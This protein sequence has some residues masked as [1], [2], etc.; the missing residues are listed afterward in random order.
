MSK[1]AQV[2]WH[3]LSEEELL[4]K[5]KSDRYRG[6][7]SKVA[8]KRR[9]KLGENA[10]FL[11]TRSTPMDAMKAVLRDVPLLLLFLICLIAL[12]FSLWRTVI[13]VLAVLL[14]SSAMTVIAYA[15]ARHIRESM[16]SYS[17]PRV[18]LIRGGKR[19]YGRAA[20]LVP[21]DLICLQA[22]DI[23]PADARILQCSADAFVR[24]L[25]SVQ[26]GEM[27][28][29]APTT[30][31]A[32]RVY[33]A[34]ADENDVLLR[35]NMLFAGSRIERGQLTA[36]V[37]TT[38]VD[39]YH[40]ALFGGNALAAE[41]GE[42]PYL[43]R[44]RRYA[45]R[46]SILMCAMLLPA[47]LIG[48]LFGKDASLFEIFLIVLS[49]AVASMSEQ[50]MVMGRIVA[51]CG[52]VRAALPSHRGS[53]AIFKRYDT[54][55]K[56]AGL[57][58]VIMTDMSAL[59]DGMPHPYAIFTDGAMY[60]ASCAAHPSVLRFYTLVYLYGMCKDAAVV[61]A[62]QGQRENEEFEALLQGA[63]ELTALLSFDTESLHIRTVSA[64]LAPGE[65]RVAEAVLRM[66]D[67]ENRRV[68]ILCSSDES[69]IDEC[70]RCTQGD[71]TVAMDED[72]KHLLLEAAK[73]LRRDGCRLLLYATRNEQGTT[74]FEGLIALRESIDTEAMEKVQELSRHEVRVSWVLPSVTPYEL[75][76][77][78]QCGLLSDQEHPHSL[79]D[80]SGEQLCRV[81]R[82]QVYTVYVGA[83]AD[84]VEQLLRGCRTKRTVTA[85][86]GL[87]AS[88]A[89][90]A[91]DLKITYDDT[92]FRSDSSIGTGK[93][94]LSTEK[95]ERVR[96]VRRAKDAD[97]SVAALLLRRGEVAVETLRGLLG[98]VRAARAIQKN[99]ALML[100]YML[101]SQFL[102]MTLVL[103][104][105]L[106]G[107]TLL[108]ASMILIS[109]MWVDLGFIL[110]L[111]FR[112]GGYDE[113]MRSTPNTRLFDHP[114]RVR[115]DRVCAAVLTG[116]VM[117]L[118]SVIL[119]WAGPLSAPGMQSLFVFA[120]LLLTQTMAILLFY[121]G[122]SERDE[123]PMRTQLPIIGM[124]LLILL[125]PLLLLCLPGF[126]A[127]LQCASLTLPVVLLSLVSVPIHA[128]LCF[129]C[130]R[131]RFRMHRWITKYFP[132]QKG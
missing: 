102:R 120:S 105:L 74:I 5:L 56:I 113:L 84:A 25:R 69:L 79:A 75:S 80:L 121:F 88:T 43:A 15:K 55:D 48:L 38:G 12:C 131:L 115:P 106:F 77:L 64:A 83:D 65:A 61:P 31:R 96:R 119:R 24:T 112:R 6:M 58:D 110:L 78:R 62:V 27:Q 2:A 37:V 103:L 72:I 111:A 114:I 4:Q 94:T 126:A 32:E 108:S 34:D 47:T 52:V 9:E 124:L 117:L 89:S 129:A 118:F 51:A 63:S 17:A 116:I 130:A 127:V 91:A 82:E 29:D 21:G 3:T 13:C 19:Y 86:L 26:N 73:R 67:G 76:V 44:M 92:P 90:D 128:A 100:Q 123:R 46:Y 42:M 101:V 33:E 40:G 30:K 98:A 87:H 54:T 59:S 109:G 60:D 95:D 97:V 122:G 10:L 57:S 41:A 1:F 23:V 50:L 68:R 8:R 53:A 36:I 104:S 132:T 39:T 18:T 11:P 7:S 125:P 85:T 107:T 49:L 81:Y 93:P 99:M 45:N 16:S 14:L 22:G 71:H 66:R 70:G 20:A 28:Y 35:E